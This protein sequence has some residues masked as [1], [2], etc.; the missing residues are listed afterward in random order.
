MGASVT[1]SEGIEEG[2]A[3]DPILAFVS[4]PA[5]NQVALGAVVTLVIV[6]LIRGWLVPR[7]VMEDRVKDKDLRIAGLEK[8]RDAWHTAHNISEEGRAEL[9]SQN[10]ELIRGQEIA[11]RFM[12]SARAYFDKASRQRGIG[13][14]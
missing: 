7:S 3:V 12:D 10:G 11:N 1:L 5:T 14:E 8:E 13:E 6:S 4:N 9:K 2:K